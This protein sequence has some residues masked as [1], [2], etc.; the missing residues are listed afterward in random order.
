MTLYESRD[1]TIK[2]AYWQYISSVLLVIVGGLFYIFIIHFYSTEI[3][4]VFSLLSAIAYLFSTAFNLGLQQGIQHFISYH[5]GRGEDEKIR[6]LVR[7]FTVVGLLLSSAAF[8]SLWLLSPA[9][10]LIF[11]HTYAFLDYLKLIDVELF[12]MIMVNILLYMLLG[13]QSFRLNGIMN[14]INFSVG[15]GLIIPLILLNDNPIRI[16][17]SWIIGYYLTMFLLFVTIHRRLGKSSRDDREKVEIGPVFAY[18]IPIFISNLVGYGATYVD[19][20]IV[21]FLV[22]LSELGIYNFALLIT[23]ALGILTL[24]FTSILLSRLSEFYG[25]NDSES[26][27]LYSLKGSEVLTAIY[28]PVALLVAALSPSIILFLAKESYIAGSVPITI[29][30]IVSSL[31]VS[32]NIFAVTLQAIRKTRLFIISS[33][34]GL[35]V[36]F[37]ISIILIP[38]F[39]IDGAAV[40]YASTSIVSFLA[41][42]YYSRKH[43]TF[44]LE[45]MRMLKIFISG[46][47]MFF[48]MIVVQDRLGYSILK[49]FVYLVTGLAVYLFFIRVFNTFD[50]RDIDLFLGMVPDNYARIKRFI[51]SLFV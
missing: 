20:F 17:Y 28:M 37:V 2:G 10:S 7:R 12:S 19:R 26:F 29:I 32:V 33:S 25:R 1:T 47:L 51:R 23:N 34:L 42:L 22:N 44:I 11:F 39:G 4:G 48:L 8:I 16:I 13:L 27:R 35:L 45:R 21:S 9:L 15:Y 24:P 50:E 18:S 30:L 43:G 31:T 3:V 6:G 5:L 14:I 40:G 49:L 38:R 41:I 46:F 36:N